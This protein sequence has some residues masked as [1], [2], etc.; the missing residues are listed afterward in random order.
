MEEA[1]ALETIRRELESARRANHE[2]SSNFERI[3]SVGQLVELQLLRHAF[4]LCLPDL[5]ALEMEVPERPS[6]C[7]V[8]PRVKNN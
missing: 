4:I 5:T 1:Q 8:R 2:S 3:R 6:S 7:L